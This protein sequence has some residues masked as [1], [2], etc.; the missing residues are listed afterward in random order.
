MPLADPED[1]AVTVTSLTPKIELCCRDEAP[2]TLCL[3]IDAELYV[4]PAQEP[5]QLVMQ[6]STGESGSTRNSSSY[7]SKS[8]PD[9]DR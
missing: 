6:N 1:T 9:S 5:Q 2:C 8:R 7:L 3:V 4:D